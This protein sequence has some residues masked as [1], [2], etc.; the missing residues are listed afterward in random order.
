MTKATYLFAG[1]GEYSQATVGAGNGN[2]YGYGDGNG[3]GYGT[4]LS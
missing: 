3:N 1:L 4:G 2:G